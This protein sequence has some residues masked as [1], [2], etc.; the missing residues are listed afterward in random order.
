MQTPASMKGG[1]C[2]PPNPESRIPAFVTVATASMKGGPCGPPNCMAPSPPA[3][4]SHGLNEGRSLRT[5]EPTD[6][7]TV[8][9]ADTPQ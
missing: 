9:K 1:P 5:A 8:A 3:T 4:A 2:G 7:K 6:V